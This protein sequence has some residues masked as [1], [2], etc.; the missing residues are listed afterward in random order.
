[1]DDLFVKFG[2]QLRQIGVNNADE[3]WAMLQ[4][5]ASHEPTELFR[6]LN[7][8]LK[9]AIPASL[10]LAAWLKARHSAN[11]APTKPIA[12]VEDEAEAEAEVVTVAAEPSA[13][14]SS[15]SGNKKRRR[16]GF[17]A[18][19][20]RKAKAVAA[21]AAAIAEPPPVRQLR[22]RRAVRTLLK[23]D[24]EAGEEDE[25]EEEQTSVFTLTSAATVDASEEEEEVPDEPE[26]HGNGLTWLPARLRTPQKLETKEKHVNTLLRYF[27]E[28]SGQSVW[29]AIAE[30]AFVAGGS[31]L[32]MY[33]PLFEVDFGK[34]VAN[35]L[36]SGDLL[37]ALSYKSDV[38][39]VRA[40]CN[41]L[42][43][44]RTDWIQYY[45]AFYNLE[46]AALQSERFRAAVAVFDSLVTADRVH[47][48]NINANHARSLAS[49]VSVADEQAGRALLAL[50][51]VALA[52][53]LAEEPDDK[54]HPL[55]WSVKLW[56]RERPPSAFD[57]T[58]WP[59]ELRPATEAQL[60]EIA[61][62]NISLLPEPPMPTFVDG[63]LSV[64]DGVRVTVGEVQIG[65]ALLL[66][67]HKKKLE[68][69]FDMLADAVTGGDRR[70]RTPA[71]LAD[72]AVVRS[73]LADKI[74]R[75]LCTAAQLLRYQRFVVEETETAA[76][77]VAVEEPE[78]DDNDAAS[79]VNGGGGGGGGPQNVD[80]NT[81]D[82][83][84]EEEEDVTVEE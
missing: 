17:S 73:R 62:G 72:A 80:D 40:L 38:V 33:G 55:A 76:V 41:R 21:A 32:M 65:M 2:P 82:D 28:Q 77:A 26:D 60:A 67:N 74:A 81:I 63:V 16:R 69:R 43:S 50:C 11:N 13:S 36:R 45:R 56:R 57:V 24:D 3:A 49:N 31:A 35:V 29:S 42:S 30:L 78:A 59:T 83:P 5:F 64:A 70:F 53:A 19:A 14:V 47:V 27:E 10:A 18:P 8:D 48:T 84:V 7:K 9:L 34:Y 61:S 66:V 54:S 71:G 52:A 68:A 23:G 20:P 22:S 79:V 4:L 15:S 44:M 37:H 6:F 75:T 12:T 46:R 1:M 58:A 51:A 25:V 39:D